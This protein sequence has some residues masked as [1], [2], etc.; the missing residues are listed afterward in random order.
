MASLGSKNKQIIRTVRGRWGGS[1][2]EYNLSRQIF[3][4]KWNVGEQSE[5]LS[6][7]FTLAYLHQPVYRQ[8]LF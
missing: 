3:I 8:G 7:L 2:E 6:R 1:A 4:I 5:H